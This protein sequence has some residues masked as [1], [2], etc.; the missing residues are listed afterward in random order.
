MTKFRN[1][2]VPTRWHGKKFSDDLHFLSAGCLPG[3]DP[4]LPGEALDVDDNVGDDPEMAGVVVENENEMEGVNLAQINLFFQVL[5]AVVATLLG[6]YAWDRWLSQSSRVTKEMCGQIR[7]SCQ[8]EILGLLK[9]QGD[10]LDA[11]DGCFDTFSKTLMVICLTQLKMC[12]HLHIDCEEIKRIMVNK[13]I[14]D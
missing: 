2:N 4:L 14:L 5:L 3:R 9:N 11:G 1:L 8:K 13:G 7:S 10:Q 12:E 6:K